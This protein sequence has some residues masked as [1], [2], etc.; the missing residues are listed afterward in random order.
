MHTKGDT[1]PVNYTSTTKFC[2][3]CEQKL[4][5]PKVKES[6]FYLTKERILEWTDWKGHIEC[7]ELTP[8]VEGYIRETIDFYSGDSNSY[9]KIKSIEVEKVKSFIMS[10]VK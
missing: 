5:N 6:T 1:I 10:Q 3:C 8:V 2:R 7:G 4:P 9:I